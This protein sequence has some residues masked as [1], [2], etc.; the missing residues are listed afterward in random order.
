MEGTG[1]ASRRLSFFARRPS[2]VARNPQPAT[3]N[4][5]PATRNHLLRSIKVSRT[6]RYVTLG[7]EEAAV[8]E[9]WFV[10]HGYGQLAS[11]FISAF[12]AID[13]GTRLFVA[14]EALN[15]FYLT[16]VDTPA[17]DR[18]VGATWMTREDRENEI[19]DYVAYLDAVA[20][21]VRSRLEGQRWPSRVIVLGFSQGTATA[22]R[23][24][25]SGSIRATELVL[26]GG[27]LPPEL[28]TR[29]RASRERLP[30]P[31]FV[32]GSRDKFVSAE[33]LGEEEQRMR[34]AAVTYRLL[35]YT[36]GHSIS[37][38]VLVT[39]AAEIRSRRA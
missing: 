11:T 31:Y 1:G 34:D 19:D 39:L 20:N 14:P 17:A 18:P 23:W 22:A 35:R 27:L 33:R 25:S 7:P 32:V 6:A 24:V 5:Q 15:R 16:G 26:W 37:P 13:D 12:G 36:G 29:P 28:A 4:P 3:R 8:A 9:V 21:D 30:P 2:P 38:D 10:L